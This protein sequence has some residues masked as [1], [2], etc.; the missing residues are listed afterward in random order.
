MS[1]P[2]L[3]LRVTWDSGVSG[4]REGAGRGRPSLSVSLTQLGHNQDTGKVQ[5]HNPQV[6]DHHPLRFIDI[7]LTLA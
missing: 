4:A 7:T 6:S 5:D 2:R 3:C 1:F